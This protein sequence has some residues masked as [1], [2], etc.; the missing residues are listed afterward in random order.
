MGANELPRL[1]QGED[2]REEGEAGDRNSNRTLGE[3]REGCERV[4][5]SEP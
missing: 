5:S 4:G 1:P 2:D 3:E